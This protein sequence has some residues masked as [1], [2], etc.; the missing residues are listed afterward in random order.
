MPDIRTKIRA[1]IQD[2][3]KPDFQ[4]FAFTNS[5]V[6]K[7]AEPN[8]SSIL[9][10]LVK[11]IQLGQGNYSFS[12]STAELTI[13]GV[14]LNVNDPV[15]IR[16]NFTKYSSRELNEY[17][18]AS[19]SWLNLFDVGESAFAIQSNEIAPAPSAKEED[20]IALVASILICPDFSSY[21]LPNLTVDYPMHMPKEERISR[22]IT[23]F[24]YGTGVG[25]AIEWGD[26]GSDQNI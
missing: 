19:L 15:E 14:S 8:I 2:I 3:T 21:K 6:F 5:N 25:D 23:R 11:G 22:I 1:L 9:A 10:V 20:L 12:M 13:T 17:I 26:L 16:Y 18:R 7:L 24:R 4:I